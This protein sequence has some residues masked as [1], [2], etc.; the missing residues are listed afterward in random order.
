[1]NPYPPSGSFRPQKIHRFHKQNPKQG[2]THPTVTKPN[3]QQVKANALPIN[4]SGRQIQCFECQQWGHKKVD[5]PNKKKTFRQP[6]PLQKETFQSWNKNWNK[7]K[8]LEQLRN[9]KINYVNVKDEQEEQAQVYA[10][11]DPSGRN[12]QITI[13]ETQGEYK[14]K[15]LTFL[16]DSGSYH[17]FIY[18]AVVKSLHLKPHPTG[19]KLR[20]SL[21]NG[22]SILE[23]EKIVDI[24]FQLEGHSIL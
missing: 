21:A 11:L 9:V 4:Q 16:I 19:R 1:M 6:L 15:P 23:E 20:V 12:R 7:G 18:L 14:G 17:S 10:A 22:T 5:C 24:S 13:L 8:I 3:V 2:F